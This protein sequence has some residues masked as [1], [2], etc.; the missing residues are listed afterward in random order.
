MKKKVAR[1][2]FEACIQGRDPNSKWRMVARALGKI[3]G[4]TFAFSLA[5]GEME[6]GPEQ[7]SRGRRVKL[8][9]GVGDAA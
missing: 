3:S 2:Q 5:R 4:P 8:P 7:E 6:I 1:Q 9:Y